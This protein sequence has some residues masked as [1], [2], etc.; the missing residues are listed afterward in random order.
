MGR[1][2]NKEEARQCVMCSEEDKESVEHVLMRCTAYR[3]EREQL[4][5]VMEVECEG[6]GLLEE[7]KLKVLLGQG[8]ER[9]DSSVNFIKIIKVKIYLRRLIYQSYLRR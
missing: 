4:W 1:W 2:K 7:E 3:S 5:E 8:G 9:I 6:W